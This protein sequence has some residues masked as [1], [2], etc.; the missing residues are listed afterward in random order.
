LIV[1]IRR[2]LSSPLIF[3]VRNL[4]IMAIATPD[5]TLEPNVTRIGTKAV[6]LDRREVAPL[7]HR[8]ELDRGA[9]RNLAAHAGQDLFAIEE[10]EQRTRGDA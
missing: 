2:A 4:Q 9:A 8:A 5:A 3:S 10:I 7:H 6:G 1:I